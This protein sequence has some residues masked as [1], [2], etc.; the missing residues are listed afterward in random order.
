VSTVAKTRFRYT[1]KVVRVGPFLR[2]LGVQFKPGRPFWSVNRH[3]LP[4]IYAAML[5]AARS[6]MRELH[7]DRGGDGHEFGNFLVSCR[8]V[9]KAFFRAG[10]AAHVPEDVRFWRSGLFQKRI[11][12]SE[13]LSLVDQGLSIRQV[14]R[15]T[16]HRRRTVKRVISLLCPLAKCK[17][18][19]PTGHVGLCSARQARPRWTQTPDGRRKMSRLKTGV[20]RNQATRQTISSTLKGRYANGFIHPMKNVPRSPETRAKIKAACNRPEAIAKMSK[21]NKGRP[22]K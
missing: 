2:S 22:K 14:S 17:C 21:A 18:G 13:I 9:K 12:V 10:L 19:R 6:K 3:L 11:R 15:R 7:P 5:N 4:T 16:G 8:A 1:S 20:P